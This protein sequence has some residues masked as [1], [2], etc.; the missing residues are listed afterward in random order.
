MLVDVSPSAASCRAEFVAASE[1]VGAAE[2]VV[3]ERAAHIGMMAHEE[4]SDPGRYREQW[5]EMVSAAP[6]A[7]HEYERAADALRTAP[8]GCT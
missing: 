6:V 8:R 3:G 1:A 2:R 4:H 7:L 5:R